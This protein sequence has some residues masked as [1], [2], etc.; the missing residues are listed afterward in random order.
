MNQAIES[1]L[2]E[3]LSK[4]AQQA[5]ANAGYSRLEQLAALKE[6]D[7]LQLHGLGPKTI[8]QLRQALADKGLAFAE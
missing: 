5:L 3:K 7:L 4:P 1:D 8:R 6:A 2:P